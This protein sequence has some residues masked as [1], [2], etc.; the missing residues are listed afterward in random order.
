MSFRN[1]F[2]LGAISVLSMVA[3]SNAATTTTTSDVA[4]TALPSLVDSLPSCATKCFATVGGEIGCKTTDL[5][6]MC[7]QDDVFKAHWGTCV[8]KECKDKEFNQALDTRDDIC[9]AMSK[10]PDS[11]AVESASSVIEAHSPEETGSG[12]GRLMPASVVGAIA[13]GA[14]MI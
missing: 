7:D 4:A 12:A 6:C 10:K 2:V 1:V 14:M 3:S 5:K 11:A 9:A 8:R 13:F